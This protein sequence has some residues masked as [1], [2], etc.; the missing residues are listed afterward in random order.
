[1]TSSAHTDAGIDHAGRLT[2]IA[3]QPPVTCDPAVHGAAIRDLIR[4]AHAQDTR[5]M[6]FPEGAPSGHDGQGRQRYAG[7]DVDMATVRHELD[8]IRPLAADLGLWVI[9]H[10]NHRLSSGHRPHNSPTPYPTEA[11]SSTTTTSATS[12]TAR[13]PTTT[14]PAPPPPL[15]TLAATGL[16]LHSASKSTF[17][18]CSSTTSSSTWSRA[19]TPQ[20]RTS[21]SASPSRPNAAP[22]CPPKSS[23]PHGVWLSHCAADGGIDFTCVTLDRRAPELGVAL[24]AAQPWRATAR[25]EAIYQR[26]YESFGPFRSRGRVR[27]FPVRG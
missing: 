19:G 15:S 9:L 5:L 22:P 11:T 24:H 17:R 10:S 21:G 8:V 6:N 1:M 23:T 25:D 18:R 27:D 2:I 13:S 20:R 12:P 4:H 7:W 26:R 16:G 14:L 3:A